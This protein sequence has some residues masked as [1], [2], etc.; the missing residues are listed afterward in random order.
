MTEKGEY[1]SQIAILILYSNKETKVD[2][3]AFLS[4]A[5]SKAKCREECVGRAVLPASALLKIRTASVAGL[6][7]RHL[8][9]KHKNKTHIFDMVSPYDLDYRT[10]AFVDVQ[11]TF[12]KVRNGLTKKDDAVEKEG[13]PLYTKKVL[14]GKKETLPRISLGRRELL[15]LRSSWFPKLLENAQD[16]Y[17]GIEHRTDKYLVRDVTFP[18]GKYK[19]RRNEFDKRGHASYKDCAMAECVEEFGLSFPSKC[20]YCAQCASTDCKG[21][22]LQLGWNDMDLAVFAA[23]IAD[24]DVWKEMMEEKKDKEQ[25]QKEKEKEKE[26]EKVNLDKLKEEKKEQ[27]EQ[28][29]DQLVGEK[30][31]PEK[32]KQDK[33]EKSQKTPS[34]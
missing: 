14:D 15:A 30:Q 11:P 21:C 24:S 31:K 27:K 13:T 8:N 16:V 3:P 28:Q 18:G 1:H 6:Q 32:E 9:C 4:R 25:Q 22:V 12:I 7:L 17:M 2:I 20:V 26:K 23:D 19:P 10:R 5:E 29:K 33:E 34:L